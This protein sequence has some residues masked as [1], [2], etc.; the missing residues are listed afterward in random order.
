MINSHS[1]GVDCLRAAC[2]LPHVHAEA[3]DALEADIEPSVGAE[4]TTPAPAGTGR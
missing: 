4:R 1:I 3:L 2:V